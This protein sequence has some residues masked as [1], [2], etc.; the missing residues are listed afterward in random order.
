MS[1][2]TAPVFCKHTLSQPACATAPRATW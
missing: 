1:H 2:L